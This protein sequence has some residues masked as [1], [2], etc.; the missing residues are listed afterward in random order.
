MGIDSYVE[1][2]I[3]TQFM[4]DTMEMS[5]FS[6]LM[7][8][9]LAMDKTPTADAEYKNLTKCLNSNLTDL[10]AQMMPT[11]EDDKPRQWIN[12]TVKNDDGT[13]RM[14]NRTW[15]N[16]TVWR[17]P[18]DNS[19]QLV[20]KL[21]IPLRKID[22]LLL[23]A[24]QEIDITCKDPLARPSQDW[25]DL[26]PWDGKVTAVCQE[27]GEYS[28]RTTQLALCQVVC[29]QLS[30]PQPDLESGLVSRECVG[31]P[32]GSNS[33]S[34][35]PPQRDQHECQDSCQR[36]GA[37]LKIGCQG[38][39]TTSSCGTMTDLFMSARKIGTELVVDLITALTCSSVKIMAN[40]ILQ[41]G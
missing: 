41:P 10:I 36:T 34:G 18:T 29:D 35:R 20:E 15:S 4:D 7:N 19:T 6:T 22:L 16:G 3:E 40:I 37:S 30:I 12:E 33:P 17:D 25:Y 24:G 2:T 5:D 39:K 13:V 1:V 31:D 9:V 11:M 32:P 23:E 14:V 27:N 28:V 26:D 38:C 8:E 21:R